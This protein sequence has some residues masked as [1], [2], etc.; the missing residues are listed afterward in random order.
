MKNKVSKK[1]EQMVLLSLISNFFQITF[2]FGNME[3]YT[4][5]CK[6]NMQYKPQYKLNI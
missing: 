3:D 2:G 5:W 1:R 6:R 4:G